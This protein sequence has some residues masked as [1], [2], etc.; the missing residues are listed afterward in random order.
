MKDSYYGDCWMYPIAKIRSLIS[1][2]VSKATTINGKALTGDITL[3]A[4]DVNAVPKT[5]TVNGKALSGNITL[6]AEDV[7]AVP[8]ENSSLID[9]SYDF[10]Y[11]LQSGTGS[12]QAFYNP[13]TKSVR[14]CFSVLDPESNIATTDAIFTCTNPDYLPAEQTAYIGAFSLASDT[15]AFKP[16]YGYID[17][18]G[19]ITQN[20]GSVARN[21][22][23]IFEY[24]VAES[25]ESEES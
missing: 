17:T 23:G 16:Y 18:T 7:G 2:L 21:C 20:L 1:G 8:V 6:T 9:I 14:G 19:K 5:R 12:M 11:G 10:T 24:L 22:L 13:V 4:S 3:T 15:S 25:E